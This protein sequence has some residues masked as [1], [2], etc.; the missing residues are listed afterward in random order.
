M[1]ALTVASGGSLLFVAAIATTAAV[2]SYAAGAEETVVMDISVSIP[3]LD[4]TSVKVGLSLV[5][6]YDTMNSE[7][8]IHAGGL[9]GNSVGPTYSVGI[10]HNYDG[11]GSYAKQFEGYGGSIGGIGIDHSRNPGNIDGVSSISI[12]FSNPFSSNQIYYDREYYWKIA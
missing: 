6:D 3:L 2:N 12:T 11:E 7:G 9:I 1:I 8:Y 10:I 5:V 4:G